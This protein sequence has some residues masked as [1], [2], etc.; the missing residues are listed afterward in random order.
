MS[1]ARKRQ[2]ATAI[3]RRLRDH[4]HQAVFAG[5]CVRDILLGREPKD[6][7]VVT[8]AT[9]EQVLPLFP[10][11]LEV[12]VPFG[13]VMVVDEDEAGGFIT[14]EVATFR[15]D[16]AYLDGRRP[17]SVELLTDLPLTEAL[18]RDAARRDFSINGMFLDP[19]SAQVFDFAEG[20]ADLRA[21]VLRAI[22]NPV[23]RFDED[24]LRMLRAIRF[25]AQLGFSVD[26]AALNV[27]RERSGHIKQVSVERIGGELTK[28]LESRFAGQGLRLLEESGLLAQVLPEVAALRFCPQD[29]IYHPEGDVLTHT[30]MAVDELPPTA[31]ARARL[32]TLLHDVGK[33][34]TTQIV[35][36][37]V[38]AY[39]HE[40]V[41][42]KMVQRILGQ[43]ES[44]FP[45]SDRA[46]I[47]TAVDLHMLCYRA[48][49]IQAKTL[50]RKLLE[51]PEDIFE[52]L[53]VVHHCDAFGRALP[54]KS[55]NRAF[56]EARRQELREAPPTQQLGAPRLVTGHSLIAL[57]FN[58]GP[59]FRQMLGIAYQAQVEGRFETEDAG[60]EFI[61]R[62]FGPPEETNV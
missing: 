4:G 15:G 33:P 36:N 2:L 55:S 51:L 37:R 39:R 23:E 34:P 56:L 29:P 41:G 35:G 13:V 11:M 10:K 48:R 9:P 30:F 46:A 8:S 57:G 26:T 38:T 3:V 50:R 44:K 24:K 58:P 22:G 1:T 6:F 45:G 20:Q 43:E 27:I 18:R 49:E 28:L 47:A 25:A 62:E 53:M 19:F 7:D 14:T 60:K 61:L 31:S 42:A 54:Q 21:G 5:G 16:G 52:N 17:S 40:H 12:G 32:A 59:G